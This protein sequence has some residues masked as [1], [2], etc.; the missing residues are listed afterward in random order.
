LIA[1]VQEGDTITIDADKL[2]LQV[3]V[4]DEE[5]A[6]RKTQWTPPKPR[7]ERGVLAK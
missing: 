5:L 7:H 1:L 4:S 2:L 3:N 6:Q